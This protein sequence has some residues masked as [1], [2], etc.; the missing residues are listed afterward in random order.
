V[1][2]GKVRLLTRT[3]LDWTERLPAIARAIG[4]LPLHAAM[5]DGELIGAGQNGVTSFSGLQ[6]ALRTGQDASL[7]FCAFDLLHLDGWDLRPCPLL[8]RKR[9]LRDIA[10]WASPLCLSEDYMGDPR[11]VWKDACRMRLEGIICKQVD[12]PYRAGRGPTWVKVKCSVRAAFVVL[13]W[14]P[15]RGNRR[16]IGALHLG[17]HDDQGRLRYAGGVGTGFTEQE[18]EAFCALLTGLPDRP[19]GEPT[20]GSAVCRRSH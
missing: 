17:Y 10:D 6:A 11:A 4:Q 15:P 14:T 3:G 18:L 16:G 7:V 8:K 2:R 19:R 20:R 12:A 1:D 5:L 13:G 9:L